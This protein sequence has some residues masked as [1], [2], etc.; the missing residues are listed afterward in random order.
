MAIA[1]ALRLQVGAAQMAAIGLHEMIEVI[2]GA[3]PIHVPRAPRYCHAMVRWREMLIPIFDLA[4][5]CG[6]DAGGATG[7]AARFHAILSYESGD[8]QR[9]GFGCLGLESFP[10]TI[11]VDDQAACALPAKLWSAVALSCFRDGPSIVPILHL[12]A[13]F[14]PKVRHADRHDGTPIRA[15]TAATSA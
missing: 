6:F 11:Q 5:W 2:E 4:N 7:G 15:R 8:P 14:D 9:P 3:E 1:S 10:V 13:L 12:S